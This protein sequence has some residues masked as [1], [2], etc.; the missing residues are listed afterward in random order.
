MIGTN[1]LSLGFSEHKIL[2]NILKISEQIKAVSSETEVFVQS[3]LPR[4]PEYREKIESL[5]KKLPELLPNEV[6]WINLYPHFLDAEGEAMAPQF[7]NDGLHLTGR[8][9]LLWRQLINSYVNTNS[10]SSVMKLTSARITPVSES[11]W[12]IAQR[13]YLEPI[14]GKAPFYNVSAT[15]ARHVEAAEKF[16]VWAYHIMGESSTL[17]GRHREMLILRVGWL[18]D[19]EYEWGQHKIF[20]RKEGL[21]EDEIERIKIGSRAEGW[22][23]IE[24]ALIDAADEL[25]ENSFINNITWEALAKEYSDQQMMDVVF[26]VGQ[27]HMVSMAL[28][29]FGVQLDE[30]VAGF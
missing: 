4:G 11:D 7:S 12:T 24:R 21:R 20:A 18:C 14:K 9:Y 3:I 29:S 10:G 2:E 23:A 19:S 5:N 28:N 16:N 30:G 22:S 25:H 1:D 26:T 17:D 8:G 13:R 6:G 27:Y 15:L